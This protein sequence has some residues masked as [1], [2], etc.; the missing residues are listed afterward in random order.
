MSGYNCACCCHRGCQ[1]S[2]GAHGCL[3]LT[4]APLRH[5]QE[6]FVSP[7]LKARCNFLCRLNSGVKRVRK[8]RTSHSVSGTLKGCRN[9]LTSQ[10]C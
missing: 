10:N 7:R 9:Q 1:G 3:I 2:D 6:V 5:T 4:A 8:P